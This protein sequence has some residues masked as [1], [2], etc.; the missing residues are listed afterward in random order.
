MLRYAL[1]ILYV[2]CMSLSIAP[3]VAAVSMCNLASPAFCDTFDFP[4]G[5]GTN[6]G[7]LNGTVWGV[8]RATSLNN[9]GQGQLMQ[10]ADVSENVCGTQIVEDAADAPQV[11]NG[12]FVE[13]VNDNGGQTVLAAY[14]RQPFDIASRTGT[15][16]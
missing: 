12:R 1:I 4:S 9:T 11:C 10:W 8:S 5:G 15:A 3:K 16:H 6:S 13:G 7:Q 2:A 14:P